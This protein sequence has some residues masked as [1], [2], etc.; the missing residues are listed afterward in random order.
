MKLT[1]NGAERE[2]PKIEGD[3]VALSELLKTHLELGDLPVLVELNGT[4]LLKKEVGK[5]VVKEGDVLEIIRMV[6]GG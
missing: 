4:A 3:E 2:F 1:I 6:A 5:G